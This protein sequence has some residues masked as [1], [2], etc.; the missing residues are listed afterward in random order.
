MHKILV[1]IL[2][3]TLATIATP[4]QG[5]DADFTDPY[6]P[7][8]TNLK[9]DMPLTVGK[10]SSGKLT[11]RLHA[12]VNLSVKVHANSLAGF[13]IRFEPSDWNSYNDTNP[14][15]A[16]WQ[17]P[18]QLLTVG[19][20]TYGG[21]LGNLQM[22]SDLISSFIK[23][24]WRY[25][26]YSFI[27][28][29]KTDPYLAPCLTK[30]RPITVRLKDL[31][32][33]IKQVSFNPQTG[34]KSYSVLLPKVQDPIFKTLPETTCSKLPAVDDDMPYTYAACV[35]AAG[36]FDYF[37]EFTAVQIKQLIIAS[38]SLQTPAPTPSSS[39]AASSRISEIDQRIT[40]LT[41]NIKSS[42]STIDTYKEKIAT[43]KSVLATSTDEKAK[44]SAAASI[45][46]FTVAILKLNSAISNG[47]SELTAL[48][49][50]RAKLI[51]SG[52]APS[53]TSSPSAKPSAQ[54]KK[55]GTIRCQKGKE[56]KKVMGYNPICP[57][58]Y[59]KL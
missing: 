6:L 16:P 53:V 27:A 30:L 1:A 17:L 58:G 23:D 24:G 37:T 45:T 28:P 49:A 15:Q 10:D 19:D 38:Q 59:V 50:E 57:K 40:F 42:T 43:L 9:I 26:T 48:T 29:I 14:C 4:S 11:Y 25:E 46:E 33:H 13:G 3:I 8:I 52:L 35:E 36:I 22:A 21:T 44:A 12:V 34:Q 5:A 7:I 47:K 2:S 31:A 41:G 51:S 20:I 18:G 55:F 56:I 32:G 54:V 39:P